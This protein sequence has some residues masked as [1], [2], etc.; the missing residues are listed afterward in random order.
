MDGGGAGIER[1]GVG[2]DDALAELGDAEVVVGEEVVEEVGHGPFK[3]EFVGEWV[4]AESGFDFFAGGGGVEPEV[5]G[6]GGAKFIANAGFKGRHG[7]KAGEVSGGEAADFVVAAVVVVP[8]LDG[9]AV[10]EGNEHAGEGGCP[11]EA[12]GGEGQF[13]DDGLMEETGE[14]G[15]GAHFVAWEGFGDGGSPADFWAG[16]K[17][18]NLLAGFGEIGGGGEAIVATAD[19][20]GVP[21]AGGEGFDGVAVSELALAG[22]GDG[23]FQRGVWAIHGGGFRVAGRSLFRITVKCMSVMVSLRMKSGQ[24]S[25]FCLHG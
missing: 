14:I 1:A 17:H 11:V 20:D 7:L 16:F 12:V 9:L 2:A 23:G 18:E 13:V 21:I 4:V 24:T 6:A 10:E 22:G 15:A 19:D 5:V 25:V 8:E 3:E